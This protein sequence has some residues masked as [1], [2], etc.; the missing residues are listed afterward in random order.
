VNSVPQVVRQQQ[1]AGGPT[2]AWAEAVRA[3]GDHRYWLAPIVD[4]ALRRV[5]NCS[6]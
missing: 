6:S 2:T 5:L 4:A 3:R 1:R